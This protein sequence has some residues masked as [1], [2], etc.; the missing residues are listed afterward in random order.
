[1]SLLRS[2]RLE[3]LLGTPVSEATYDHVQVLID[4]NVPE[5]FDLDYKKTLYGRSDKDK[6]ELCSDVA[7]LANAAGGLII[8]GI[9]EDERAQ[10]SEALG[11][12]VNDEEINRIY[13]V[14]ASG[15]SPL[16]GL[17]VRGL[18]RHDADGTGFLLIAVP[19]SPARPHAVLVNDGL[20][21]PHRNGTT[22]VYWSEPE[23]ASAYRDRVAGAQE[24]I[25]RLVRYE[26]ELLQGLDTTERTFVIVSLLPGRPGAMRIDTD[27][28]N[29]FQREFLGQDALIAGAAIPWRRAHVG[30]QRF[31]ASTSQDGSES[32]AVCEFHTDGGG[33]FASLVDW[34]RNRDGS[35]RRASF[36]DDEML[37]IG[38]LSGL[39]LLGRHARDRATTAGN[40]SLRATIHPVSFDIP[41]SLFRHRGISE[42]V[43]NRDVSETPTTHSVA[44]IDTLAS[45]GPGLV[46]AT[47]RLASDLFQAFGVAESL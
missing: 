46:T 4:N 18:S 7:A 40:A 16:P 24:R 30:P 39:R 32:R 17:D 31:F 14:V 33:A 47:Y 42:P 29:A 1:M 20:R 27:M 19:A 6:R 21:Y 9:D 38:L 8:L 11:V 2:A 26:H 15:L 22:T 13:Q 25:E 37:A 35:P 34:R 28:A 45:N 3:R 10:A 41:A 12:R 23:V 44:D 36:V 5:S 43:G